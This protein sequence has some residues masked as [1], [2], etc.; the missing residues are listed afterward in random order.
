MSLIEKS[1]G[2]SPQR[3]EIPRWRMIFDP[4]FVPQSII[5]HEYT[6]SGTESDPYQVSWIENDPR[7]PMLFS[8]VA[9]WLITILV[10]IETLSVALVSSAYSGSIQEIIAEFKVSEEV[11]LLGISLFVLGFA[12][13]PLF[14]APLSELYGRRYVL[15]ASA[16]GLTVFTASTTGSKNIWTLIILRFCGGCV[17]SAPFAVSGAVIADTFPSIIRGLASGLYCAAPFLGPTLGPIVGGFLSEAAGWRWVEGLVACFSALFAIVCLFALPET[18]APVLL[19]KRAAR[20]SSMTGH[21]YRSKIEI[22]KGAQHPATLFKIA[23]CRP[24]VLLFS[25]P[26]VLLLS[27]YLAIIYGM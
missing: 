6:G 25:E 5:E 27:I 7:N 8:P 9:R 23:L 17:G 19:K 21:V 13:G 14:W 20:L 11:A 12:V 26:I 2:E 16:T 22:E 4:G 3:S 24:W 15:I 10:G 18:Y 1:T